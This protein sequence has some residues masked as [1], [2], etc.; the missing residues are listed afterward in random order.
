MQIRFINVIM[1]NIMLFSFQNIYEVF[2]YVGSF[3]IIQMLYRGGDKN[4]SAIWMVGFYQFFNFLYFHV[5]SVFVAVRSIICPNIYDDIIGLLI[6]IQYQVE[7]KIFCFCTWQET[8]LF[9]SSIV[10]PLSILRSCNDPQL[11]LFLF[12]ILQLIDRVVHFQMDLVMDL[13]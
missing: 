12:S 3:F 4:V 11:R 1:Q 9:Y 13:V 5:D 10:Q 6:K 2:Q 8:N 7:R